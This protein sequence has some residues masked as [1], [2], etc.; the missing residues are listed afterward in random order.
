M[1]DKFPY[2]LSGPIVTLQ[3]VV[4]PFRI[5]NRHTMVPAVNC[6]AVALV[7]PSSQRISITAV[8]TVGVT[9]ADTVIHS[10]AATA[11][12]NSELLNKLTQQ[13]GEPLQTRVAVQ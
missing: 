2:K 12:G 5:G 4:H 6:V 10:G 9:V 8:T 13:V 3:L 11:A 7:S 1:S